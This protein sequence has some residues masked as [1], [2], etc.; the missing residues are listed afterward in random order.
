MKAAEKRN[1]LAFADAIEHT[2]RNTPPKIEANNYW[3]F[4]MGNGTNFI[5]QCRPDLDAAH[6]MAE[7]IRKGASRRTGCFRT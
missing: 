6:L 4:N 2:A 5:V 3:R 7:K 1:L